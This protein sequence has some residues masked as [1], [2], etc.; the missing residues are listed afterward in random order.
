MTAEQKARDM[1]QR[2]GVEGA[3]DFSAG[4]LA[5]LANL[6]DAAFS[7]QGIGELIGHICAVKF[8]GH[9]WPIP[10]TPAWVIV[11][12]VDMPMLK[13]RSKFGGQSLW[14]NASTIDNIC[15]A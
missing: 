4:D 9:I 8:Q 10:G 5:E 1:L 15:K 6:I 11:E 7:Q 14:V 12:A 3:Q 13:M 2:M